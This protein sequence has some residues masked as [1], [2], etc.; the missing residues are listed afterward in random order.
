MTQAEYRKLRK[1][2]AA[3]KVFR[4]EYLKA[5]EDGIAVKFGKAMALLFEVLEEERRSEKNDNSG[6]K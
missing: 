5:G 3:L 4:D 6:E 1:I 2:V